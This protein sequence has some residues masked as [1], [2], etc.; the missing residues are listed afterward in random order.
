MYYIPKPTTTSGPNQD[1]GIVS[2]TW[3]TAGLITANG[4]ASG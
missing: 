3:S 4:C 2:T 1:V